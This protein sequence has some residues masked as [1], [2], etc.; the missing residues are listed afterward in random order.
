MSES[1]VGLAQG[2]VVGFP[3]A[4]FQMKR[5]LFQ[6]YHEAPFRFTLITEGVEQEVQLLKPGSHGTPGDGT[7]Y[8]ELTVCPVET[9]STRKGVRIIHID[10]DR[11]G[12]ATYY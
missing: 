8:T 11:E 9:F 1:L 7:W 4:R 3:T 12:R 2:K 5:K 10:V 6:H